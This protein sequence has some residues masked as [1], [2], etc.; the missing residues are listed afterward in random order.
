MVSGVLARF[1]FVLPQVN[2]IRGVDFDICHPI[3][4]IMTLPIPEASL[5][6]LQCREA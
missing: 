3:L 2:K 5:L 6:L 4:V 1:A